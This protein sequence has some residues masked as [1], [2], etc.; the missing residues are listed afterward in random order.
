MVTVCKP[1]MEVCAGHSV[2]IGYSIVVSDLL[3]C[4]SSF[5]DLLSFLLQDLLLLKV[6]HFCKVKPITRRIYV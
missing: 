1:W 2:V 4:N 6:E 5:S 3:F